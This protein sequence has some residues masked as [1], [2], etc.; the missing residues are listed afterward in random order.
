MPPDLSRRA[1]EHAFRAALWGDG[2]PQGIT[3][4]DPQ[5]TAQRFA[6]YRNNVQHS[7]TRALAAQ[8]PVVEALVGLEFFTAMARVFI[9]SAPPRSPV[10]LQWGNAFAGFLEQFPPVV[11][12]PYLPDV[13]RLEYDHAQACHAADA[14]PVTPKLLCV[15]DPT[16]L[17][18]VLHP[19]VRLFASAHPAVQIWQAHQRLGGN[20]CPMT[21]Y[22]W[23]RRYSPQSWSGNPRAE[24]SM[25][26]RSRTRPI[27][28]SSICMP[29]R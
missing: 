22:C 8:F 13:A 2:L 6:V 25:G 16:E 10:L 12:L 29:C 11:H 26:S 23:P 3:A 24:K 15:P 20:T 4:P 14:P 28:S 1:T 17:R 27:S 9:A 21:W 19:S 7:L 18:L 5:E